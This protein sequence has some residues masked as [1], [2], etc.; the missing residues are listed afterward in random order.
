MNM[1]RSDFPHVPP[2]ERRARWQRS[3]IHLLLLL[4]CA[5]GVLFCFPSVA[6]AASTGTGHISGQLLDGSRNNAPIANQSVT[7]QMALGSSTRDLISLKT[8]AQGRYAFSALESDNTVQYAVYTLYQGA[9]YL[10]DLI[11]LSKNA[12]QQVNLTVYD[13][14]TSTANL[15]V[16]QT[17]ILIDKPNPQSGMFTVSEDFVFENLSNTTY[18]GNLDGS[19]GKPNAL[20]FSLPTGAR[21]LTLD[22]SFDGYN[23]IQ[24]NT[25]FATNAAV[26]P[27][28]SEYSFSFQVPY[29]GTSYNF[30][31]TAIYPTVAL[32]LLTPLNILTTPQ[33]LTAKGPSNTQTGTFQKFDAQTLRAN[34]NVGVQLASLPLPTKA[35]PSQAP[36][37]P[38][39]L[40]L[41]AGLIILMAL[42]GIGA[43]L[44]NARRRKARQATVT[45]QDVAQSI[46]K[47]GT[48]AANKGALLQEL[49]EL[50]RAHEA[51]R[52]KKAAY[53]ERRARAKARLRDLMHEQ[54][55]KQTP[56]AE[57]TAPGGK[58][59]K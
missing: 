23:S 40:W 36:V 3:S 33:G 52:I 10:T 5:L 44:Y 20:L 7:L 31:Y 18:V 6:S 14:T 35:V 54:S 4:V 50:D 1:H 17:S 48:L 58:G 43:Y 37:N 38:A 49:L 19:K 41:V 16:I 22:D 11:D 46:S 30:S 9:Q 21:F 2:N 34:T 25:G 13:A 53:Q 42:A 27:G 8:D 12:S 47:K 57:K 28:T 32:T 24:V 45:S 26:L 55:Q 56:K 29:T 15:A 39:L 59:E 51:G